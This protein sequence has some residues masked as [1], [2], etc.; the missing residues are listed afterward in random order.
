MMISLSL[1]SLIHI[2][3]HQSFRSYNSNIMFALSEPLI[4]FVVPDM[5]LTLAF[6]NVKSRKYL[7]SQR[8]VCGCTVSKTYFL[9]FL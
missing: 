9:L 2:I 8:I 7:L 5:I 1:C 6:V 4:K 3:D